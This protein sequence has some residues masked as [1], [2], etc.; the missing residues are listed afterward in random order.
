MGHMSPATT[1]P[2]DVAD[3]TS[4]VD[5][6]FQIV[7]YVIVAV[8]VLAGATGW[9]G[10][11]TEVASAQ[12]GGYTLEV[13]HARVTRGGLAA[14]LVINVSRPGGLP[15]HLEI[16]IATDYLGLFDLNGI[17]PLPVSTYA[18]QGIT[19]WS[20]EVPAGTQSLTITYDGRI[21]PA[22]QGTRSGMLSLVLNGQV[23]ASVSLKTLVMP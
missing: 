19:T 4:R 21:E 11:R 15:D 14:P 8:L 23:I 22:I 7:L 2:P 18:A 10:V 9:I 13:G 5:L 6:V 16:E 3:E 17:W 1:T 20:F 12:A